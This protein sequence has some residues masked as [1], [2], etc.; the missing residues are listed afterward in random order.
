MGKL[1]PAPKQQQTC[2]SSSLVLS[3]FRTSGVEKEA[4]GDK[5]REINAY[6][7]HRVVVYSSTL[8]QPFLSMQDHFTLTRITYNEK[9]DVAYL[10]VMDA[11][12]DC[13][14]TIMQ[15]VH[16]FREKFIV[17]DEMVGVVGDAKLYE[18]IKS[19]K[20]EYGKELSWVIPYARDFHL[21]MNY[22]KALV[23]PYY[24][25]GLKSLAQAA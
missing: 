17:R 24:D 14:D 2:Y 8:Q 25:T 11:V 5:L 1:P 12:A 7:L 13:R 22:Q 23:K 19:V 9:S 3:Y 10:E 15:L 4:Q 21:L 6:L 20:F 18:V 16:S